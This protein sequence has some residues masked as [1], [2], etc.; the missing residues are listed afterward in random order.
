MEQFEIV[1]DPGMTREKW[2]SPAGFEENGVGQL[3]LV[4]GQWS[5]VS[6]SWSIVRGS[7][8]GSPLPEGRKSTGA[9]RAGLIATRRDD[10][11]L[12][13]DN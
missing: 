6:C 4:R 8:L 3:S 1:K 5:V 2:A 12:I 11:R 7:V 9:L 10:R 13:T